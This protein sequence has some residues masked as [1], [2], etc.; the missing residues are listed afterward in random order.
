MDVEYD[1][2]QSLQDYAKNSYAEGRRVPAVRPLRGR[3]G[4]L[5]FDVHHVSYGMH[6]YVVAQQS[7][8]DPSVHRPFTW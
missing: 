3:H 1:F 7:S 4:L 8:Q 5:W 6:C 2:D